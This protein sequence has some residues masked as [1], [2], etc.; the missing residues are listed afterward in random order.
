[1][2]RGMFSARKTFMVPSALLLAVVLTGL[3]LAPE[4]AEAE[5]YRWT[6][7]DGRIHFG[8][9]MP[10]S[11]ATRGYDVINPGT[12]EVIRHVERVKTPAELA[13]AAAAEEKR[14]ADAAAAAEEAK[15]DEILLQLYSNTSDIE[16][17]RKQR[18]AEV[19]AQIKQ[20]E[21]ALKRAER[22]SLSDKPSEV[23]SAAKDITHLRKTLADLYG[24]R[25]EVVRQFEH[26]LKRFEQLTAQPKTGGPG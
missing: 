23:A 6:T 3:I 7:P 21:N 1:M 22:R 9:N 15:K 11:Q 14:H 24:T 25:D 4:V 12:G 17:A 26:D 5:L 8:D 10:S 19:N 13:A 2:G 20:V 18:M 16:R